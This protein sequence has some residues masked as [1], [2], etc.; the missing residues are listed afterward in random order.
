MIDLT[1]K[2]GSLQLKNPVLVASGTFGYASECA[3]L[4]NLN[5]L[6]GIVTKA[7]TLNPRAGNPP[8]RIMET[9]AGMLNSI[10]L[11]NVGVERFM[12]EKLPFLRTIDTTI[13]VNVAGSTQEEY[14]E[15][16][17]RLETAEGIAGYEINV[18]CPN[19]KRGGMQFGTDAE[20]A[21][22][23]TKQ[24]RKLTNRLLMIKLT[25]N[26][27]N[28]GHIAKV[29]E[30]A[31]ADA[32]S[33]INTL[34]GMGVDIKTRKPKIATIFGGLSGPAIKPVA[35]A[36]VF[37]VAQNVKI[38]IIGMGGIINYEDVLEFL[39]VGATAIQVGTATFFNPRTAEEIV[40]DLIVYGENNKIT[41]IS[42]LIGKLET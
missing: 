11:A 30:E 3:P 14:L 25:P 38:P 12:V 40:D 39:L 35:L 21:H 23:L 2:I 29:V 41:A 1:V 20:S 28:I 27:T 6:G 13:L 31:G 32:V 7:I 24:L 17:K 16:V 22:D 9:A 37:E 42:D 15:V 4:L 18:S 26:V 19:V 36:K 5:R 33:V 34:R 10:G 8:P